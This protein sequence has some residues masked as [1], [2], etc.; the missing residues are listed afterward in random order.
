MGFYYVYGITFPQTVMIFF[1]N[2]LPLIL[3]IGGEIDIN[4]DFSERL[5]CIITEEENPVF[6]PAEK[7]NL[8]RVGAFIHEH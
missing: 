3:K 6:L 7:V 1:I 4:E 8:S 2:P 5:H